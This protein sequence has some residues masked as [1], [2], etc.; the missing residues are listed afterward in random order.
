MRIDSA[1]RFRPSRNA[2]PAK[3]ENMNLFARGAVIQIQTLAVR[4]MLKVKIC[5]C[6]LECEEIE[7]ADGNT[8]YACVECA[9]YAEHYEARLAV[10]EEKPLT[11]RRPRPGK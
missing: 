1:I 8:V 2:A 9:S 7:L 11:R 3:R 5:S 4:T 6:R 10:M